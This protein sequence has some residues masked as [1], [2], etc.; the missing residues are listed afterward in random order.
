[1]KFDDVIHAYAAGHFD[2]DKACTISGPRATP[3]HA[4]TRS[5]GMF[6]IRVKTGHQNTTEDLCPVKTIV[7][8]LSHVCFHR[9]HASILSRQLSENASA[10]R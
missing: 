3:P 1:M 8:V 2:R 4:R 9:P 6:G 5:R 7:C 10:K